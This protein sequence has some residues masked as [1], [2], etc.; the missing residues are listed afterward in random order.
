L[1][2]IKHPT[3]RST[4]VAINID[5]EGIDTNYVS[6][7]VVYYKNI[8]WYIPDVIAYIQQKTE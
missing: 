2:E 5:N 4:K 8:S 1:P 7:K 3:I 6:D